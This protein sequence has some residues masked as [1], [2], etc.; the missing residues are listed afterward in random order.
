MIPHLERLAADPRR[1]V[2]A[3]ARKALATVAKD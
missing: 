3:R 2:A 1:S